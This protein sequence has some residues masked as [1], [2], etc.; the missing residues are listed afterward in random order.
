MS[1]RRVLKQPL[2]RLLDQHD[3]HVVQLRAL[4]P[5]LGVQHG[6]QKVRGVGHRL[7]LVKES[8]EVRVYRAAVPR[9]HELER[10]PGRVFAIECT[11]LAE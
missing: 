3:E 8:P 9:E 1:R 7:R 6:V 4:L 5:L 10:L 2:Y 11:W